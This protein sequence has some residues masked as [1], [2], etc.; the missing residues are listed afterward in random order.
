MVNFLRL[1]VYLMSGAKA[2]S[3]AVGAAVFA[4]FAQGCLEQPTAMKTTTTCR[5]YR[6]MIESSPLSIT[7]LYRL[8]IR[9]LKRKKTAQPAWLYLACAAACI[10]LCLPMAHASEKV[11]REQR[12]QFVEGREMLAAGSLSAAS[13]KLAALSGYPL[14]S[15][16]E[17]LILRKQIERAADPIS[18]LGSIEAFAGKYNDSRSHRRLIGVLKNRLAALENW[19]DYGRLAGLSNA[20]VHPCDDLIAEVHAGLGKFDQPARKLWVEP[21]KHTDNCNTAFD[22]LI[23]RSGDVPTAE[24]WQRT[25]ALLIGGRTEK[26]KPLLRFYGTRDRRVIQSWL[27]NIESPQRLLQSETARGSLAH[28]KELVSHLLRRW[29]REDLPAATAFWKRHGKSFGYSEEE[30]A[31]ALGKH[32]VLA[33]KKGLPEAATLLKDTSVAGRDVRYWR[34]RLALRAEDWAAVLVGLDALTEAEQSATRWQYWRARA[35]QSLGAADEARAIYRRLA[36][37]FEYYGFLAADKLS[38]DY[39]IGSEEVVVDPQQLSALREDSQIA[40]AVE[41]FKVDISWEGR[42]AW[43]IALKGASEEKLVAAAHYA[44]S[45][46]WHDRAFASIKKTEHDTALPYLFPMPHQQHIR[47]VVA[48]YPVTESLVY[49]VMRQESGYIADVRSPAGAVGLMQLMPATA[50]E[51][52]KKIGIDVPR[53]QLIDGEINIRL[54]TN[55]LATV[56]ERFDGNVVL[57]AAA[58]NAGPSRVS[59]W[60]SEASLA[61][62][63]WV[64]TIP[65]DET[66]SYVKGVLFNSTVAEWRLKDRVLTRLKNRMH[67]VLPLG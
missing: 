32:A 20:P 57:A 5:H 37:Q 46:G 17:Y 8:L 49:G 10:A 6:C 43:N 50:R 11:L 3:R 55:Y 31:Q 27:D 26:V 12:A 66:R 59:T 52:A 15:H 4:T 58:Y 29:M 60:I 44:L 39:N 63:V 51:V 9:L 36:G 65:F 24:L 42:R 40:T 25:V 35:M 33:A 38:A 22:K 1:S 13:E 53:W 64:E 30:L 54:G 62:D 41:F 67:D 48:G 7:L 61:A 2:G 14:Q 45:I 28:H 23:E 47:Q 21:R 18:M 34:V 16:Y 19:S 56:L